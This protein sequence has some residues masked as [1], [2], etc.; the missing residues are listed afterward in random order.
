MDTPSPD[1]RA[2]AGA[3]RRPAA[4]GSTADDRQRWDET[5]F[6]PLIRFEGHHDAIMW[7]PGNGVVQDHR[8][9][10]VYHDLTNSERTKRG[11][12]TPWTPAMADAEK[13]EAPRP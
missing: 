4:A 1:Q 2:D 5:A 12:P 7:N 9:G 13:Y 8:D 3:L 11:M 10:T 6:Y